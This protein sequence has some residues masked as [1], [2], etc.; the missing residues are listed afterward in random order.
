MPLKSLKNLNSF[1]RGY[2]EGTS[3]QIDFNTSLSGAVKNIDNSTEIVFKTILVLNEG[4]HNEARPQ[5]G[6]LVSGPGIVGIP[7]ITSVDE[8][9]RIITEEVTEE[10][11]ASINLTVTIITVDIAQTLFEDTILTLSDT[12]LGIKEYELTGN[13]LSRS[14][15]DIRLEQLV[16]S[17]LLNYSTDS[18]YD[19]NSSGGIKTFLD[20]YYKFMNTEEFTYKTFETFEDIVINNIST[21]RISNPDLSTQRFFS[22]DAARASKFFDENDNPLT[23]GDSNLYD[24]NLIDI[25]IFNVN[26]L[27]TDYTLERNSGQTV[28]ITNLPSKLNNKK[29]KMVT[30]IQNYVG[31][32]PSYRLHTLEDSLNI[33]ETEDE[34]LNM[35]Q[36]EIAPAVDQ[37]IFVNKRALY[38]RLIDFYKIRGSK[39]SID[40]FFKL[41][42]QDEEINIE[43]PWD[44]TLK[45]SMGKWDPQSSV[46]ANY[47]QQNDN[48]V[49]SDP[50]SGDLY[51]TSIS[52][53]A[54]HNLIAIGAPGE[55]NAEGAVY[56][57][58][59]TNSGASWG[60]EAKIVSA[61]GTAGDD[62]GSV[63][64]LSGDT[65]A[66]SAPDD[67]ANAGA[68]TADSGSVEIWQRVLTQAPSTFTWLY[69][70]TLVHTSGGKN[71]GTDI[72]LDGNTLAVT[73][74]GYVN[75][76]RSNG[77]ILIYKAVGT[78]WTLSQT[79]VT[80]L[81]LNDP[82]NN[83]WGSKVI[84]RGDYIVTSWPEYNNNKGSVVVFKKNN[85]TGLF[86]AA[87][88]VVINPPELV[89][90]DKFGAS[91][92]IDPLNSGLLPRLV[93]GAT[94]RREIFIYDRDTVN[95]TTQWI[96]VAGLFPSGTQSNDLF[97]QSIKIYNNNILVSAPEHNS[98][99]NKSG[100][101][102]HFESI[103]DQ[104]SEVGIYNESQTLNNRF[105]SAIEISRS[106]DYY[107]FIGSPTSTNG[108]VSNFIRSSQI[109]KYLND[110]GFLSSKQ[111]LQDSEFY[112]RFSYVIKAGRNISQWKDIYNKLVH[113][114][115]F[116]YFGE[117]LVVI[118]AVRDVLGDGAGRDGPLTTITEKTVN[119]FG[120][121]VT[122]DL[123]VIAYSNDAV[124][125]RKTFSSMPGIQPGFIGDEDLGLLIE[126]LV[127][128]FTPTITSRPNKGAIL[129]ISKLKTGGAI[130]HD[131]VS[132][133]E[134]GTS[135]NTAPT[136]TSSIGSGAVFETEVDEL[137]QIINVIVKGG[138]PTTISTPAEPSSFIYNAAADSGRTASQTYSVTTG[139]SR[140]SADGINGVIN[141]V[142]GSDKTITSV[143]AT[144]AG[145]GY[146]VGEV[147]TIPADQ[148]GSGS[149]EFKLTVNEIHSG[150]GYTPN[151]T[152]TVQ[153]LSAVSGSGTET[154]IGKVSDLTEIT[155]TGS[156]PLTAN[157]FY[158]ITDLGDATVANFNTIS[159][160][161]YDRDLWK[162][163]DV[164]QAASTASGL[165]T[166]AKLI[167]NPIGLSFTEFANKEYV[168][169][170]IIDIGK[171]DAIDLA[172]VLLTSNVTAKA[173]FSLTN[174][175]A[176]DDTA[177]LAIGE[178]YT[179]SFK[180]NTTDAD[181]NLL[182][183]E[184]KTANPIETVDTIAMT[185]AST[186]VHAGTYYVTDG[187]EYTTGADGIDAKFKIIIG[188]DSS[189]KVEV[190]EGDQLYSGSGY[191]INSTFTVLG[192]KFQNGVSGTNDLTFDVATLGN[193]SIGD[194]FIAKNDGTGLSASTTGMVS[195]FNSGGKISG[196][197]ITDA[198]LGYVNDPISVIKS[199]SVTEKRVPN[200]IPIQ[201]VTNG[202][203]VQNTNPAT[204]L[205]TTTSINRSNDYFGRKDYDVKAVLG[206][207]KFNG[208]YNITQ[209]SALTIENVGTSIINKSNV[210]TTVQ[211]VKDRNS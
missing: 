41:F 65:L 179:I 70:A 169:P 131:G 60:S 192:S 33:N 69:R 204:G 165:S 120:D 134:P 62:F 25:N 6:Q 14:N 129:S 91:F 153:P 112:Q 146:V 173:T 168:L 4:E 107:L 82:G 93:V 188:N 31:A 130:P 96:N 59:T 128:F 109:G 46:A 66:I 8:R 206:T 132:I 209:F 148:L 87:P 201:I 36:K 84:L 20:A 24:I 152:L 118:K 160:A 44:S 13:T 139:G 140:S 90:N 194:T 86:D 53:D 64:S 57:Y 125:I 124:N 193:W 30:S 157:V 177:R 71:F 156:D 2:I 40:T 101:V 119:L 182:A 102:Y 186:G 35:M 16:P 12:N 176:L 111:K 27:P 113:P 48:I 191:Q 54:V 47:T 207:K 198:G 19:N 116:K 175:I 9:L 143:T 76:D 3:S 149:A 154:A 100:L 117:I 79:I 108:H 181:F 202:N 199:N 110:E 170:P 26:N 21:I 163:G 32:G 85:S 137:G 77:A 5:V 136:V 94:G 99:V 135:Y 144:T 7:K 1:S 172:G 103:N 190:F 180:G 185:H 51:G 92:D 52:V 104:W 73:V 205:V 97:A 68:N 174:Q 29:I 196:F 162:V 42:F 121:E 210:N 98:T 74:P 80:P 55:T 145:T 211:T 67:N 83:G 81:E 159:T 45:T 10:N 138:H 171:P 158:Q 17:E 189:V 187:D 89:N 18:N 38:Q 161:A 72:S 63:V 78:N 164:F 34:F 105:G 183:V 184:Q 197:R 203:D 142:V 155:L 178:R 195:L 114:A 126:A 95:N 15:E 22:L 147:I 39:D 208:E 200:V 37:N 123:D 43:F 23:V 133:V 150:S 127:S 61:S 151:S 115:G 75:A 122:R 58:S 141:V 106:N 50:A 49:A 166:S 28:S 56:V 167:I 11:I 88:D